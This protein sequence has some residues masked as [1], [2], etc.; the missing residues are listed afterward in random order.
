MELNIGVIAG[1]VVL[2]TLLVWFILRRNKHDLE[3]LEE[4]IKKT[5]LG[6]DNHKE[7]KI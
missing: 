3:D 6:E 4:T 1:L 7:E 5:D 2:V